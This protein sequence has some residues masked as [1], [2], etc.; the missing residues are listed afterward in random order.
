MDGTSSAV[1]LGTGGGLPGLVLAVL[2]GP[3]RRWR[4]VDANRRRC[5]FL[6]GAVEDLGL[7]A[8]VEVVEDRAEVVGRQPEHRGR[9]DVVVVRS[10]GAPAV[11]AECAAPLLAVGGRLLVSEPP[12]GTILNRWPAEALAELGMS[13]AV[14]HE[15]GGAHLAAMTQLRPC[16]DRYPRRVGVPAKRPLF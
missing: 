5:A 16:P 12:D 1:D 11:V 8:R 9:A 6:R 3:D 2:G 14:L 13:A 4:L 15:G 10:F 7:A